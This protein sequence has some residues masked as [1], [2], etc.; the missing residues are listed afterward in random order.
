MKKCISQ[1][2]TMQFIVNIISV[3]VKKYSNIF[4]TKS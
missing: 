4:S 3:P 1:C 2:W